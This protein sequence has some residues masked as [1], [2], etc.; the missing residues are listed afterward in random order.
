MG[1]EVARRSGAAVGDAPV[2]VMIV[3]DSAVVRGLVS[4]WLNDADGIEV[5]GTAP[6]GRN[7]VDRIG[8]YRPDIVILDIEM[9]EM[10][11]LTAL[12]LLL[13]NMPGVSIIM[14]STL[15]RRNAEVSLKAL[16]L[17]ASD[18]IPKPEG[19]SGVTTSTDFRREIVEKVKVL[20]ARAKRSQPKP[21]LVQP[22]TPAP[23]ERTAVKDTKDSTDDSI[24]L[25]PSSRVPPRVLLIGSSTGGPPALAKLLGQLGDAG[26]QLPILIT[27]HMPPTFTAIL[28]EH[29]SK[30]TGRQAAEGVNGEPIVAGRIYVAP[31]GQHMVVGGTVAEPRIR[32]NDDPPVNFCRPAVDP[33]FMSAAK[34][35]GAS[36]L[37]VVLTGMG[38]DGAD[39]GVAIADGG[40]TVI[41]QDK[42][43]S[44]VW[45]MP[46]A[47]AHAGC[48]AAVLPLDQIAYK[49]QTLIGGASR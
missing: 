41:A 32:L 11:G 3:D 28:A 34:V 16:S 39:G 23:A 38:H 13:K 26:A 18:Y 45:G 46:G 24:A 49:L 6:N 2:R 33:L 17:G 10:D 44:V 31:G 43:S 20:G 42:A 21:A 36:C 7:A 37:S 14:A 12:P 1:I 9:P 5:V 27:Q 8:R 22:A 30:A 35:F 29:L 4:R 15:T 48:C 19:N 25:K 40:G 47:T